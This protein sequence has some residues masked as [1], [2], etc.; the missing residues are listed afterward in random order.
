MGALIMAAAGRKSVVVA[1]WINQIHCGA[2]VAEAKVLV[3]VPL[4]HGFEVQWVLS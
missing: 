3:H 1:Q 2:R 4:E